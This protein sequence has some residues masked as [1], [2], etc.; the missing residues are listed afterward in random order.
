MMDETLQ[1]SNCG[2]KYCT[3]TPQ[4]GISQAAGLN[5]SARS[6]SSPVARIRQSTQAPSKAPRPPPQ[7]QSMVVG[8]KRI[9]QPPSVSTGP[10]ETSPPPPPSPQE[11]IVQSIIPTKD[12]P[13]FAIRKEPK[14]VKPSTGPKVAVNPHRIA[15]LEGLNSPHRKRLHR[16]GEVIW[17]FLDVPIAKPGEKDSAISAWPG[18]VKSIQKTTHVTIVMGE[19]S[20][21]HRK[22]EDQPYAYEVSLFNIDAP[23]TV[24]DEKVLPYQAVS[25]PQPLLDALSSL[26]HTIDRKGNT[27][28]VSAEGGLEAL[29][30][31][32]FEEAAL[33]YA[34][35]VQ[36]PITLAR[37]WT[38]TDNWVFRYTIVADK[39]VATPV[40]APKRKYR[41]PGLH[42]GPMPELLASASAGPVALPAESHAQVRSQKRYQGLWWGGERIWVDDLVRLKVSR[43]ELSPNGSERVLPIVPPS[44]A[45]V[46]YTIQKGLGP[47]HAPTSG[48]RG[49]FLRITSIFAVE[50]K[51]RISGMLFDLVEDGFVGVG[52]GGREGR[53]EDTSAFDMTSLNPALLQGEDSAEQGSNGFKLAPDRQVLSGPYVRSW[54]PPEPPTGYKFRSILKGDCEALMDISLLSG[55]YFPGVL[56]N[57]R[58]SNHLQ[59][60]LALEGSV[61]HLYAMEGLAPGYYNSVDPQF[62]R[63]NRQVM[64]NE[65]VAEAKSK[66]EDWFDKEAV[67]N[68]LSPDVA[69]SPSDVEMDEHEHKG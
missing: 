14:P 8:K 9:S 69:S 47:E 24:S 58:L 55:R 67:S 25:S 63:E 36:T 15:D 10:A 5:L 43:R 23:V 54:S 22:G 65:A 56:T 42:I 35:A 16:I 21:E 57:P 32:T 28:D 18:I 41:T 33:P 66:C 29:S 31:L 53:Q 64:L 12:I 20:V 2:C 62:A 40:V 6:V 3:R 7:T 38:C 68:L 59:H 34:L 46:D 1:R 4:R 19:S 52:V 37:Y 26:M 49:L 30:K 13:W 44:Q 61:H 50:K 45:T 60:L 51:V 11:E 27:L 48:D 39:A 17:C